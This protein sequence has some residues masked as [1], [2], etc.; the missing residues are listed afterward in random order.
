[1]LRIQGKDAIYPPEEIK[2]LLLDACDKGK[3]NGLSSTPALR[4]E[5]RSLVEALEASNPS[6]NP[7]DSKLMAGFWRLLYTTSTEGGNAGKLGPL[8]GAVFQDID[9]DA[10]IIKNCLAH[11]SKYWKINRFIREKEEQ[12]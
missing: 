9:P 12:D 10:G 7:A 11:D 6:R 1:M 2:R 3:P 8:V 4:D 5:I